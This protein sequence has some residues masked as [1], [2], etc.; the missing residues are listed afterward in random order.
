MRRVCNH[1][2]AFRF[3]NFYIHLHITSQMISLFNSIMHVQSKKCKSALWEV[4]DYWKSKLI[5][6]LSENLT[7]LGSNTKI[8]VF[9]IF[10]LQ[11][12]QLLKKRRWTA[13]WR[14]MAIERVHADSLKITKH[15]PEILVFKLIQT[16]Q[17][18]YR[19]K[20][21]VLLTLVYDDMGYAV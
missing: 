6:L 13:R 2:D 18:I 3:K 17:T 8:C 4:I 20:R 1:W 15:L 9:W 12:G 10:K 19:D 7:L 16:N 11:S 21:H 14:Q 5:D